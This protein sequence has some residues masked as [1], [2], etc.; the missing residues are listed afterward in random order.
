MVE[1]L[2]GWTILKGWE[3]P[4]FTQKQKG[5]G[6]GS[7]GQAIEPRTCRDPLDLA[8]KPVNSGTPCFRKRGVPSIHDNAPMAGKKSLKSYVVG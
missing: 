2:P 6:E 7:T 4:T 3:R 1:M 5:V 8:T